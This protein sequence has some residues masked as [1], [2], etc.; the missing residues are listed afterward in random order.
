MRSYLFIVLAILA[1]AFCTEEEEY[2]KY[3]KYR[4]ACTGYVSDNSTT[5][6]QFIDKT[7]SQEEGSL[8]KVCKKE[9]FETIPSDCSEEHKKCVVGLLG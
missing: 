7:L 1:V 5:F 8:L 6:R 2:T 9:Y 3:H 4:D